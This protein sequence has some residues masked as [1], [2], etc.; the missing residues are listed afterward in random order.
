MLKITTR[1]D[2]TKTTIELEGRLAGAWVDELERCWQEIPSGRS[3][4]LLLG[5]VSFIDAGGKELL[6][7]IYVRG[8]ELQA[9]GCMTR[10]IVQEI[11]RGNQ[12]K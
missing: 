7:R 6:S 12:A 4:R 11:I 8:A 9:T 3:L 2:T 5:G 1:F 10:C